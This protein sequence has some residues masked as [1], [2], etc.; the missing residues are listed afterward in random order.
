MEL[1]KLLPIIIKQFSGRLEIDQPGLEAEILLAFILGKNREWLM[2]NLDQSISIS[3]RKRLV[4]LINRRLR[5]EPIA[6]L[7]GQKEFYGLN[8]LITKDV[9]IPRPET[10]LLVKEALKYLGAG[11]EKRV[12]DLGTGCGCLA[13][14]IAKYQ[15]QV[16]VCA[17]DISQKALLIA[18]KNAEKHRVNIIFR[19]SDL[20]KNIPGKFDLIIGN[21]PY[22]KTREARS[23][24]KLLYHPLISLDGG[25][26]GLEL[27]RRLIKE[28]RDYLKN[29]GRLMLEIAPEQLEPLKEDIKKTYPQAEIEIKKDLNKKDRVLI[30]APRS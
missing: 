24:A 7:I 17:S 15:P 3:K 19:K 5:G 16:E 4:R 25:R 26:K 9:L 2:A 1:R 20:F 11:R 12:I 22:I 29:K 23:I 8:F 10:E 27:N 13:I 21:L 6:Y 18:K 30:I 28:S 14:T